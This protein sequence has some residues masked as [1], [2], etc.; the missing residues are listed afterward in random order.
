MV[1][2][3]NVILIFIYLFVYKIYVH[4]VICNKS[5]SIRCAMSNAILPHILS[6]L[7]HPVITSFYFSILYIKIIY[8]NI[9]ITLKKPTI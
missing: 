8:T 1:G 3:F 4:N 9:K 7:T 6:I 2:F 5:I